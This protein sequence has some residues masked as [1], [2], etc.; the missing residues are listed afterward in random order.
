MML[1]QFIPQEYC[2]HCDVCCRFPENHTVWTPKFTR[3]E[4]IAAVEH[5]MIPSD[6]FS[7]PSSVLTKEST[8]CPTD[9][10]TSPSSL[11]ELRRDLAEALAKAGNSISKKRQ[12]RYRPT[13][14]DT[15]ACRAC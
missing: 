13:N 9:F 6:L 3:E 15:L 7:Q 11:F 2:L 12:Y 5:G 8:S 14:T 1:E 10:R 4:V